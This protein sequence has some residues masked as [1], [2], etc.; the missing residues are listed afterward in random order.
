MHRVACRRGILTEI[1][2][3][4]ASVA[5][6]CAIFYLNDPI[7][8]CEHISVVGNDEHRL[9]RALEPVDK[10]LLSDIIHMVRWLIDQCK[11][12]LGVHDLHHLH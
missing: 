3:V 12:D 10:L 2:I 1:G 9:L 6:G 4:V 7:H 11:V 8:L 5:E